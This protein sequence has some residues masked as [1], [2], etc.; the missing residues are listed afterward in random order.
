MT[1]TVSAN[2]FATL[3]L[4][5]AIEAL[6][7]VKA[8]A[9]PDLL[10]A[11]PNYLSDPGYALE[12]RK[13]GTQLTSGEKAQ[14]G[15]SARAFMSKELLEHLTQEGMREPTRAHEMTLQRASFSVS[16]FQSLDQAR[17]ASRPLSV[18]RICPS[19]SGCPE[20]DAWAELDAFSPLPPIECRDSVYRTCRSTFVF[21]RKGRA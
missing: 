8:E 1:Q 18:R 17:L 9:L 21:R 15:V 10:K 19:T 2:D 3:A 13:S 16:R 14:L 12:W 20:H 6:Q 4:M 5:E 7:L 11:L